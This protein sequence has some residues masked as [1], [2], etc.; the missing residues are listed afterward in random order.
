MIRPC[1]S[2]D[3]STLT[4]GDICLGCLQRRTRDHHEAGVDVEPHSV[5]ES[6]NDSAGVAA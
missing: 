1:S 5:D 3:C 6:A 4:Y 2:P